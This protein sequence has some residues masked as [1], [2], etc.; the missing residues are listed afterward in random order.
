LLSE[1]PLFVQLRVNYSYTKRDMLF[2]LNDIAHENSCLSKR[3][4]SQR[5]LAPRKLHCRN[6]TKFSLRLNNIFW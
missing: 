1:T 4:F 6:L 2:I 3:I 5:L